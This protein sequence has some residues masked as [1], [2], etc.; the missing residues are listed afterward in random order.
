MPDSSKITYYK[1]ADCF[2]TI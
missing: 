1:S 2:V